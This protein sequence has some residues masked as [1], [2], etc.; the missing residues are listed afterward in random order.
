MADIPRKRPTKQLSSDSLK[1]DFE[2]SL[3]NEFD[4]PPLD[5]G[6]PDFGGSVELLYNRTSEGLRLEEN[7]DGF[8]DANTEAE[9]DS[10]YQKMAQALEYRDKLLVKAVIRE[11]E[12]EMAPKIKKMQE[13]KRKY[14]LLKKVYKLPSVSNLAEFRTEKS[15]PKPKRSR[16]HSTAV[17]RT[18][19]DPIDEEAEKRDAPELARTRSHDPGHEKQQKHSAGSTVLP[20]PIPSLSPTYSRCGDHRDLRILSTVELISIKSRILSHVFP[21]VG[22]ITGLVLKFEQNADY[23]P[24]T[25]KSLVIR[26]LNN[27]ILLQEIE[28]ELAARGESAKNLLQ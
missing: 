23:K 13:H 28:H 20:I 21:D 1:E 2:D 6:E 15:K 22:R 10:V 16:S 3:I 11:L 12:K 14:E 17:A 5:D 4:L 7:L 18:Q 26:K 9:L 25:R 8:P 27:K 19:L 24:G